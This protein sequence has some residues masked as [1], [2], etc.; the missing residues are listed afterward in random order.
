MCQDRQTR[1]KNL[2]AERECETAHLNFFCTFG[3]FFSLSL[4]VSEVPVVSSST[5]FSGLSCMG[6][7]DH[8]LTGVSLHGSRNKMFQI[9]HAEIVPQVIDHNHKV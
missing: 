2:F 4:L 5:V 8:V 6:E 3:H 9:H 7:S 1:S